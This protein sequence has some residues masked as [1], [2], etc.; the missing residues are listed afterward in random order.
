[1][2][3]ICGFESMLRA[4]ALSF[5]KLRIN[6]LGVITTLKALELKDVIRLSQF[7]LSLKGKPCRIRLIVSIHLKP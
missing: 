6:W 4:K 1:M 3:L 7:T 2:V 5:A